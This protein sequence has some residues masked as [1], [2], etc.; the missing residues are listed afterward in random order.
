MGTTAIVYIRGM[1]SI[2]TG[3]HVDPWV[4]ITGTYYLIAILVAVGILL[5]NRNPPKTLAYLLV[6]FLFPFVGL[7]VYVLFGQN[8]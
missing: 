8:F 3:S 4:L 5:E 2:G 6:L 7:M 1:D